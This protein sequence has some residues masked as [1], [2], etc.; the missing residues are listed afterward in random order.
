LPNTDGS[1]S[2]A[3]TFHPPA[4]SSAKTGP[5]PSRLRPAT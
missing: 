5:P 4:R 2:E 1:Y 3:E